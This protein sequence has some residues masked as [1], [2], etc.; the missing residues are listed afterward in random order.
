[1]F[2][3]IGQNERGTNANTAAM[4]FGSG[5]MLLL[6]LIGMLLYV[7]RHYRLGT[8][9]LAVWRWGPKVLI[10]L[11]QVREVRRVKLS[12]VR[13]SC[14]VGG[15]FGAWGRFCTGDKTNGF[16]DFTA[17]VTRSDTQVALFRK[18]GTVVVLSPDDPDAFIKAVTARLV[19]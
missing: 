17:Y 7:P 15:F 18:D 16:A 10:P 3:A 14:G 9:A 6:F 5:T 4:M 1:M 19:A 12:R 11:V 2:V 8:T 13:R